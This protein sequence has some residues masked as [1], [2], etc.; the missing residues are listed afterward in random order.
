M[1]VLGIDLSS[2]VC[3]YAISNEGKII[4]GGF[5]DI[6]KLVSYKEKAK[7]IIGV[8]KHKS[9]EK[10]QVEESL[11]S[12]TFGK[13]SQQTILKLAMNKA[14]ICYIL[15]EEFKVEILSINVNT[16]RKQLFGKCRI[17]GV[18]S[19]DFV[20]AELEKLMPE[21]KQ[22]AVLNKKNNW[23][24]KNGDMYDAIVCALYKNL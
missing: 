17:K 24:E 23:D 2:T 8:L 20:K 1:N 5:I 21:V 15:E 16:M 4:D 3:G 12:F 22:F 11:A 9:F 10:I 19:K 6:S 13:S 14:V 7:C 18:K